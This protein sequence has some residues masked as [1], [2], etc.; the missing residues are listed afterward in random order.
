LIREGVYKE[1]VNIKTSGT[2]ENR[3]VFE[4]Q[5]GSNGEYLAIIDPSSLVS[6][7]T[8]A[9]EIGAGV[10]K[11]NLGFDPKEMTVNGKR[12]GRIRD[13]MMADNSGFNILNYNEDHIV[14]YYNR[15]VVFWDVAG[16]MYGYKNGTTYIRFKNRKHDIGKEIIT[17]SPEGYTITISNKSYITFKAL[18]FN[19]AQGSIRITGS[20]S[21]YNVI[22]SC[23]ITNGQRRI[24]IE[25][26]AN[27]NHIKNNS[28]TMNY[29]VPEVLGAGHI[30]HAMNKRYVY[31]LFKNIIGTGT[32]EDFSVFVSSNG[33][34]NVIDGNYVFGG[35]IGIRA[36]IWGKADGLIISNNI[37]SQ[38][39]SVGITSGRGQWNAEYY[40][41]SIIDCAISIR[42]HDMNCPNDQGRRVYIY[43]NHFW[44]PPNVGVAFFSWAAAG[45]S[46]P[47]TFPK[48]FIYHNSF[49]FSH[50]F[51]A[52]HDNVRTSGGMPDTHMVNNVF[53]VRYNGTNFSN[54]VAR[55]GNFGILDYNW[56]G[57]NLS[58]STFCPTGHNSS[59]NDVFLWNPTGQK[60]P[61]PLDFSY[62]GEPKFISDGGLDLSKP[63]GPN[64]NQVL[65]GMAEAYAG[66][67]KLPLG[68]IPR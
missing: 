22:D 14:K 54:I 28:I 51:F 62:S 12:I 24:Y 41:N 60:Y 47:S 2:A 67:N 66:K 68:V 55:D 52:I 36:M 7:W 5:R 49:T 56:V 29:Y 44:N 4:G 61:D 27:K 3:I 11:K 48:Y 40:G 19:G 23:Y 18:K 45:L 34:K 50:D 64:N 1:F 21:S 32:S 35:M 17:A 37:I 65:P 39:S 9:T 57:G 8:A 31:H 16:A 20:S 43:D 46:S 63:F 38:M 59:C 25:S 6:G 30:D 13:S 33:E 42:M 15:D 58:S 53:S 10:Y 26:G